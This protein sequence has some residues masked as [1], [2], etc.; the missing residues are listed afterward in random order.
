LKLKGAEVSSHHHPGCHNVSGN[1]HITGKEEGGKKVDCRFW[2]AVICKD[3]DLYLYRGSGTMLKEILRH[4]YPAT[5]SG[6][7]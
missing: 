4:L 1:S 5:D 6:A 3:K 2:K 7:M